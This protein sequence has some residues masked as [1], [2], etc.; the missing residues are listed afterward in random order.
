MVEQEWAFYLS[1]IL[2]GLGNGRMYPAFLNMFVAMARHDQRGTANSSILTSWDIG[3]GI[4]ILA[5]GVLVEYTGY[6]SAFWFTA[7]SQIAGLLL[8]VFLPAVSSSAA[9]CLPGAE[10]KGVAAGCY[11][12]NS[13]TPS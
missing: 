4:G 2:V 6:A 9:V 8:V 1:A 3:M 5:G 12:S 7:A 11:K 10:P 13:P